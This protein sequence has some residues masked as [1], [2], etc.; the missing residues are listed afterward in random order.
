VFRKTI[1]PPSSGL[2]I[3]SFSETFVCTYKSTRRYNPELHSL[4]VGF[5]V[6]TETSMKFRVF[7]DVA[8][9]SHVEVFS[10][11]AVRTSETSVNFNVITWRYIPED[12]KLQPSLA[13]CFKTGVRFP[14]V[15]VVFS[16]SP[17]R[18]WLLNPL[19]LI[20]NCYCGVPS[21]GRGE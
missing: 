9:C 11:E 18:D 12:A 15:A 5:Q 6:L 7:W 21:W 1:L 2:K 16:F 4:L 19:S 13:M 14:A 8:P 20:L 10:I 17:P 3:F